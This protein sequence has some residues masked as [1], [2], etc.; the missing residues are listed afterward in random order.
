MSDIFVSH[1]TADDAA[2]TQLH[3]ALEQAGLPSWVDHHNLKPPQDNWR[4][5]IHEALVDC[6]RVV[7]VLSRNAI[8]RPEIDA[9]WT[10]AQS[11][12]RELFVVI[13]DDVP[14]D[15]INYRLH[16]VQWIN[17]SK[18]LSAGVDYLI[19]CLKGEPPNVGTKTG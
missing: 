6:R 3:S 10:Y 12:G 2:V 4:T 8:N 19:A 14:A 5:A 11:N 15:Q 9:E 13:I 7:L 18:D 1:A 17:L 16:I